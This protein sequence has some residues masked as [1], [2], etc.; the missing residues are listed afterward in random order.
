MARYQYDLS[1]SGAQGTGNDPGVV[2][3]VWYW[4][5]SDTSYWL[6]TAKMIPEINP[7]TD[8]WETALSMPR[9]HQC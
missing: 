4:D 8:S 1:A 7:F 6:M 2:A 9:D 5:S 3:V